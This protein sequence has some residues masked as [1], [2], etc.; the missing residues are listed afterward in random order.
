MICHKVN[1]EVLF[2]GIVI[3]QQSNKI[4]LKCIF[5]N[6]VMI[7]IHQREERK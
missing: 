3:N 1:K 5:I 2:L 6:Q 7:I 4:I